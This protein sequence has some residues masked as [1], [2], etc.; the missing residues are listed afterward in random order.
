M[1]LGDTE[2]TLTPACHQVMEAE[3]NYAAGQLIFL[4]KRFEWKPLPPRHV[5]HSSEIS[6]RYFGIP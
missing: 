1:M 4:A 5:L 2:Q 6:A 3:A